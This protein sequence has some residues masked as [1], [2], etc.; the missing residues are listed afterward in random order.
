M[1]RG[2]TLSLLV[3]ALLSCGEQ[4]ADAAREGV[5][6]AAIVRADEVQLRARPKL[7]AGKYARMGGSLYDFYRGAFA[8]FLRDA[9]DGAM[10]VSRSAF[11]L[12]AP[13]PYAIGDPHVENFGTLRA[14]D[15]TFA[16]EPNDYDVAD[17]WPYLW[18][19]R[20]L[21]VGLLVGARVSNPADAD[22]RARM[23]A[24]GPDA[25]RTCARAYADAAIALASGAPRARLVRD[26]SSPILEDLFRRSER[27]LLARRELVEQ[28]E[29][30]DGV[31]RLRRG[32]LDPTD[33][34]NVRADLPAFALA[35]LPTTLEEYRKTLAS[36][37][38]SGFFRVLDAVRELGTGVASWA[39]IRAL[40]LVEGPSDDRS[41]DVILEVKEEVDSGA[42]EWIPP[43]RFFDDPNERILL[44]TRRTWARP[45]AEPLWGTSHWVGLRVQVRAETEAHKTVRTRRWEK[46]RGTPEAL[47]DLGARLG[48]LLANVHGATLPGGARPI[49]AIAAV[50]RG[51]EDAFA[52][53]QA[54]VAEAYAVQ[55]ERD[56]EH[57]KR[58]LRRLGPVLGLPPSAV[59]PPSPDMAAL[60]G[61]PPPPPEAP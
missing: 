57:F 50:L 5:V 25:A 7:F 53:E 49:E 21:L 20:R 1:L 38:P 3:T 35:A 28:T 6:V 39:R 55:V 45:D 37:P 31:R 12:D 34:Q 33:T 54:D 41:D 48:A 2:A 32:V 61:A 26:P 42:R 8:V 18:D 22:A 23:V 59:Q 24:A 29:I 43:G 47:I 46:E 27:D 44:T 40:V 58:A 56:W 17:R 9:A 52:A 11:F 13:M 4:G 60:L 19:V 16:I 51:R 10:P 36:P 14:A 30:V 15:G